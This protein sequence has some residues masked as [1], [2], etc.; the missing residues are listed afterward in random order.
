MKNSSQQIVFGSF[1]PVV[2]PA[3][4]QETFVAK[5]D[6]GAYSGAIHCSLL[7]EVEREGRKVLRFRPLA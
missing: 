4:S 3:F 6:T 7:K 2:L 5:V 1:E